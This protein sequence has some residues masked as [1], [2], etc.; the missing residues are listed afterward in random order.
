MR[1]D[2]RDEKRKG[3]MGKNGGRTSVMRRRV[4]Q[5][6]NLSI[7][8]TPIH[9]WLAIKSGNK[10][11]GGGFFSM[12]IHSPSFIPLGREATVELL[13]C[14]S[15]GAAR[16]PRQSQ[17]AIHRLQCTGQRKKGGEGGDEK[18]FRIYQ[19]EEIVFL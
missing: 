17:H 7:D 9:P 12:A 19:V 1:R 18:G 14:G 16:Y 4:A 8:F 15:G 13:P 2:G 6:H 10:N 5:V 3:V 11:G